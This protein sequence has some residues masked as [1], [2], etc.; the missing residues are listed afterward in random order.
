MIMSF[1][2]LSTLRRKRQLPLNPTFR[3]VSVEDF[4]HGTRKGK[5]KRIPV[6]VSGASKEEAEMSVAQMVHDERANTQSMD[7]TF[8]R[9]VARVGSRYK[10]IDFKTGSSA[11]GADEDDTQV[12]MTMFSSQKLTSVS[13][14]QKERSRQ[15][16]RHDKDQSITSRFFWWIESRSFRKHTLLAL[17]NHVSMVMIPPHLSL[18]PG[19]QVYLVPIKVRTESCLRICFSLCW[20]SC[21]HCIAFVCT[22]L[23]LLAR[24]IVGELRGRCLE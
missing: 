8:A 10:G 3:F 17:G 7:E 21:A 6:D 22:L 11:T 23:L 2:V 9:N 4:R 14:Q 19:Q 5:L 1:G 12:D 16:A 15:L 18:F 24:G 20:F 13:Q